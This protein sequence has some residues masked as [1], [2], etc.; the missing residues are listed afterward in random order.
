M[1]WGA[2]SLTGRSPLVDVQ[3]RLNAARYVEEI[4]RPHVLPLL[5]APHAQFQQDNAR[6]HTARL[7]TAFLNQ[8]QVQVLPWPSL[9]PDM[10]PIEHLWDEL[11]R[12]V[13]GREAAP[14][15]HRELLEALQEEWDAIPQQDIRA[16]IESMPRRCRQLVAA[17]G[18]HTPY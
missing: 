11:D 2:I 4:L 13:R 9:S 14:T 10:N 7:T 12:R 15:N 17:R 6:P 18:G 16:L 5:N 8:H 3:G 1:V